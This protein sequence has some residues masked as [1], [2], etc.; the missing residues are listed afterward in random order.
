MNMTYIALEELNFLW[1][2]KEVER[3]RELWKQ[4][5]PLKEIARQLKRTTEETFI[6]ALDQAKLGNVGKRRYGV[7]GDVG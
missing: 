6:L 5:L 2:E 1:K 3:F 7:W 4:G